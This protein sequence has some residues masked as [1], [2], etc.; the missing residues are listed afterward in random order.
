MSP[1]E[2]SSLSSDSNIYVQSLSLFETESNEQFGIINP[3]KSKG[4]GTMAI[5]GIVVG[6]VTAIL[7]ATIVTVVILKR[8]KKM[9]ENSNKEDTSKDTFTDVKTKSKIEETN[10]DEQDLDFWL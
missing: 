4:I 8:N 1:I 3:T 9:K 10:D 2:Y 6:V 5:V 7:I